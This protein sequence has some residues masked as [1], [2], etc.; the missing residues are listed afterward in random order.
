M[1]QINNSMLIEPRKL[2]W[3]Y[4]WCG[5]IPFV[6][7]LIEEQR[8]NVIVELGTH[9]GNSYL[10]MCQAVAENGIGTKCYA[11]DTWKGDEHAGNYDEDVYNQL[12]KYH[13]EHY[14][15]FSNLMRMTFDEANTYFGEKSIDL[16]HIDGFHTYESVE[17][18]F[19]NWLFKMS[20]NG[21]VLFHDVNVRERNFGVWKLWEELCT[22]YPNY[23]F[24]HSHGLGVL[25]V[26][27]ASLSILIERLKTE[28]VNSDALVAKMFARLGELIFLKTH[29]D[30]NENVSQNKLNIDIGQEIDRV[31]NL[32]ENKQ[33]EIIH[34]T[35]QLVKTV[36]EHF[37][38]SV[39]KNELIELKLDI[40]QQLIKKLT[41]H[42]DYTNDS[43]QSNLKVQQQ[44]LNKIIE[45]H[46]IWNI[47]PLRFFSLV[48]KGQ[49]KEAI[50]PFKKAIRSLLRRLYYKFP[51]KWQPALLDWAIKVHPSWFKNHPRV[52]LNKKK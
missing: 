34:H 1:F 13:N 32:I 44:L 28:S 24:K 7:W 21:I 33:N 30:V 51:S 10:A 18:D 48:L 14:A 12:F 52:L 25:F 38:S 40:Q 31:K 37:S 11:V 20:E 17:H 47:Q 5:H 41:E 45:R 49:K 42:I 8:P 4:G 29:L 27:K 39:K 50:K 26:G 15:A 19:K 2:T 23:E 6:S 16:L 3:P 46:S 43:I 9:S 22:Q 35:D 36:T